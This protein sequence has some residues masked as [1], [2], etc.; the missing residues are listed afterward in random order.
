[1]EKGHANM[2]MTAKEH[3]LMITMFT[4]M[5]ERFGIIANT[6]TSRGIWSGDDAAAFEHAV[7]FDREKMTALALQAFDQYHIFATKLGVDTKIGD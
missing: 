5:Y 1:M 2:A 7:R 6:L 3:K 4:C